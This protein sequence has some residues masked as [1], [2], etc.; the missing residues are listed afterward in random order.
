VSNSRHFEALDKAYIDLN[1]V[2]KGLGDIVS[3]DIMAQINNFERVL[4]LIPVKNSN[5]PHN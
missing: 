1:E 3:S 2:Q 4:F 5:L